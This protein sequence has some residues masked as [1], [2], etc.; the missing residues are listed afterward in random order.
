VPT[1]RDGA[2]RYP[3]IPVLKKSVGRVPDQLSSRM[4]TLTQFCY[5]LGFHFSDMLRRH[6]TPSTKP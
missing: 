5:K 2:E 6:V 1:S 4:A 3:W